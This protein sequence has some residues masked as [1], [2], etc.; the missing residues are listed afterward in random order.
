MATIGFDILAQCCHF[1]GVP[2]N[3]NRHRAMLNT[4]R[5]GLEACL[6]RKSYSILRQMRGSQI[7]I[8]DFCAQ[9]RVADSTANHARFATITVQC[10]KKRLKWLR[11]QPI[12]TARNIDGMNACLAQA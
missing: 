5:H 2:L 3:D 11:L 6:L 12:G 8:T 10:C 1:K 9:Q 4:G 7:D